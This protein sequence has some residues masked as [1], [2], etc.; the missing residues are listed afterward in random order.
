MTQDR[1]IAVALMAVVAVA[2]TVVLW[3]GHDQ[4]APRGGRGLEPDLEVPA[5]LIAYDEIV[6]ASFAIAMRP[7]HDLA[8]DGQGRVA[9]AGGD[10]VRV[11]GPDGRPVR[12]LLAGEEVF[13]VAWGDQGQRLYLATRDQVQVFTEADTPVWS[14]P[15]PR[16]R[17]FLLSLAVADDA[18][19]VS[20]NGDHP[21][22]IIWHLDRD[23]VVQGQ[24]GMATA[25]YD[26]L[27][28]A[29]VDPRHFMALTLLPEGGDL[30]VAN[31]GRLRLERFARDG[32]LQ[33]LIGGPAGARS[34]TDHAAFV[35]C[36]NPIALAVLADG[37][38]VTAEKG[39]RFARVKVLESDGSLRC[40][41]APP[42]VFGG[43]KLGPMAL[44]VDSA[45]RILLIDE[46]QWTVRV[47]APRAGSRP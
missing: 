47:F 15:P 27:K 22:A 39:S 43:R 7:G 30:I 20:D 4:S 42:A 9:V 11:F 29:T 16:E 41:V 24:F 10:G 26:G 19:F 3:Q 25:D 13:A 35:G 1:L 37:G 32:R 33:A 28:V 6:E 45:G 5:Q 23:G 38:L 12:H 34:F 31:Q 8:V 36:C 2:V 46:R 44:A 21:R 14:W 40:Y 17:A 18:V